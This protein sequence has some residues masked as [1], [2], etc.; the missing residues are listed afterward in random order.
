MGEEVKEEKKP[1]LPAA[2]SAK[3][4][5]N[6]FSDDESEDDELFTS[7]ESSESNDEGSDDPGYY[8]SGGIKEWKSSNRSKQRRNKEERRRFEE[9]R[10]ERR[11]NRRSEKSEK[12]Q[13]KRERRLAE[14]GPALLEM[15]KKILTLN[16]QPEQKIDL[17]TMERDLE[18]KKGSSRLLAVMTIFRGFRIVVK[19]KKH[20]DKYT[21]K[22][23]DEDETKRVL[24]SMLDFSN[25]DGQEQIWNICSEVLRALMTARKESRV[26]LPVIAEQYEVNEAR[27]LTV[28][29]SVLEGM[30]MVEKKADELGG[31][32]YRGPD[33][34][35]EFSL[36]LWKT[37]DTEYNLKKVSLPL[38]HV[39]V[40]EEHR[41]P[42]T[43]PRFK[44]GLKHLKDIPTIP[45]EL[46][47]DPDIQRA[48]M[49][50]NKVCQCGSMK[51]WKGESK[52][53]KGHK[54]AKVQ[55]GGKRKIRCK[56]CTGCLAKKCMNCNHCKFPHLKKPCHDKVC[57][58]P[59]APKCP[60]FA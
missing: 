1:N 54:R 9:S 60:C 37:Y 17:E 36:S 28:V 32:I 43:P 30:D 11:Q 7:D 27:R 56:K 16:Y 12:R 29:A 22:G 13:R 18:E 33:I 38:S 47:D 48:A 58:F 24:T 51:E 21:W 14:E 31:L 19:D 55:V 3:Q 10:A 53:E 42:I 6:D 4:I 23:R 50:I 39:E 20:H 44:L 25:S 35:E 45:K 40:K 52:G 8:G 26:F 59:I 5:E 41:Y 2:V 46:E 15:T 57:L 49:N 34:Y